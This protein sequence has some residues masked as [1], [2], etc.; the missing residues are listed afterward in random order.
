MR[1]LR[2]TRSWLAC[3]MVRIANWLP[4]ALDRL[5]LEWALR[6]IDP[7]HPDVP[8]IVHRLAELKRPR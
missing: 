1:R 4:D 7:Q 6:E 3:L 2:I 5:H 8:R